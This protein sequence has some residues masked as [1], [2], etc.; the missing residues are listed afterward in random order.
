MKKIHGWLLCSASVVLALVMVFILLPVTV[1]AHTTPEGLQYQIYSGPNGDRVEITGCDQYAAAVHIPAEIDG[2][3]VESIGP[4][5]FSYCQMTELT[6]PDTVIYIGSYAFEHCTAL[7]KIRIPQGV[8][9]I[10]NNAFAGCTALVEIDIPANVT[11]FGDH[12]FAG[13]TALK[14][15][16]IPDSVTYIGSQTFSGCTA[17]EEIHIPASVTCIGAQAFAGCERLRS[18]TLS[19]GLTEIRSGCFSDCPSLTSLHIPASVSSLEE[20]MFWGS[21]NLKALT[22]DPAN[23]NFYTDG[24]VVFCDGGKTLLFCLP[25]KTGEYTIA[26]TVTQLCDKAFS[27]CK[28]LTKVH[29]PDS[30]TQ[31]G[32]YVFEGCSALTEVRLPDGLLTV[33]C[34]LFSECTALKQVNLPE[35]LVIID[36]YAFDRCTS[37]ERIVI[38]DSVT[39][40]CS[41]AFRSCTSLKNVV[42]SSG[43][44]EIA[45]ALFE[46][47][48]SLETIDIPDSVITIR[49][50]AFRNCASLKAIDLPEGLDCIENR[51]FANCVSLAEIYVP[52]SVTDLGFGCFRGCTGLTEITIDPNNRHYIFRD[53]A[54]LTAD[55]KTMISLI[56]SY[57]GE[58]VMDPRV[59]PIDYDV[60]AGCKYLTNVVLNRRVKCIDE[61]MFE[62]CTSL[63]SITLPS[64]V[65]SLGWNYDAFAGCTSLTEILVEAG[66]PI[67]DSVDGLL[68]L[69]ETNEILLCPEGKSGHY[70]TPAG[71]TSIRENAFRDCE[72]LIHFTMSDDVSQVSGG[73]L[74]SCDNLETVDWSASAT[75]IGAF[76]MSGC[77][78]LKQITIPS[79]VIRID[80]HATMDCHRLQDVYYEGT[81]EQWKQVRIGYGNESLLNAK[82][83]F[84]CT[85]TNPEHEWMEGALLKH[86]TCTICGAEDPDYVPENPFTDVLDSDYFLN[87]V[88]WAVDKGITAGTGNGQ[89]S[90]NNPCTRGQVVTF[91]WRAAGQPEPESTE[92]PFTD[93]SPA[94]YFYQP[95]LW[96]VEN[97][98]TAGLNATTFGPNTTCTRGQVV[99]FLWRAKGKPEPTNAKND[100]IDVSASDYFH[101]P[102]L[103]AVENGITAGMG[104]GKFAPNNPCTRG[105]VV[106]FLYR[107]WN[108]Q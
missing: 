67:Y 108:G 75:C 17:L 20:G 47:C 24:G 106:T 8:T 4:W 90:P 96:A 3:P 100:F 10:E 69:K 88:L 79:S 55:G 66:N 92:N 1:S 23:P 5:A 32:S 45:E 104:G 102:V 63:T 107:A 42:L 82:L 87:P 77:T 41:F 12:A 70:T 26:D 21:E 64:S 36:C 22:V 7:K 78:N 25:G 83:H 60:F 62:G 72:N 99:T 35:G 37:L 68:C 6:L 40:L 16:H 103:W 54:L 57:V 43:L 15:I 89:F 71:L 13:C 49:W 2:M 97:G 50:G 81:E 39:S 56:A 94:D 28:K 73:T 80:D 101:A 58:Y 11:F 19:E 53:G 46:N 29:I 65:G 44:T 85:E 14:K 9:C 86:P 33:S 31:I 52:A 30:V 84:W 38:P 18:V 59:T 91:L 48:T 98:I 95:V 76:A 105:Q 51:A 74:Y 61:G 93:V 27:G 34:G